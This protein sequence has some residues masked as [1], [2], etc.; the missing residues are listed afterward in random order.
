M[1]SAVRCLRFMLACAL[2]IASPLTAQVR[3]G[4]AESR[5]EILGLKRWTRKMLEDSVARYAPG[6][7]LASAACMAILRYQLHFGDALVTHYPGYDGPG[8]SHEFLSVRVVEPL[9]SGSSLW[10]Q[11]SVDRYPSLLPDYAPL[12]LPVTDSTGGIWPGRLFFAFQIADS[13]RR[14]QV[15]ARSDTAR[16][17]DHARLEAFLKSHRSEIDR[18]HAV[19]VLDSS[20]AYGNRMAAAL[21]LSNFA[22]SDSTWYALIRALRDPHE[23]VRAAA[24]VSL[25]R[26]P[27]R[28]INWAPA[29]RDLR[30]ILGGANLSAMEST[31]AMLI[32]TDVAPTLTRPIL[33]GN[34]EW[35]LRL[36]TAEAP[37]ASKQARD[38]LVRLNNGTDLGAAAGPWRSW[39]ATR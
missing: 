11:L 1:T 34:D 39:I 22:G 4:T 27:S 7:T 16:R 20:S 8:S 21:V 30:A 2:A 32:E 12:I 15:L 14:E 26:L 36:L 25:A 24:S 29:A 5:V 13:T 18:R 6:E 23:A 33:R 37:M 28:R 10:R 9:Q 38:F 35:T 31:M 17:A 3:Y 19:H